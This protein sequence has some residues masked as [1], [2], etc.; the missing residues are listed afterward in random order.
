MHTLPRL[1]TWKAVQSGL[2]SRNDL[3][4]CLN[5]AHV[6]HTQQAGDFLDDTTY[7]A[8]TPG[9]RQVNF[10]RILPRELG[11]GPESTTDDAGNALIEL[12]IN[13]RDFAPLYGFE[14]A[15]SYMYEQQFGTLVVPLPGLW[16]YSAMFINSP[17]AG[18]RY[19]I[20]VD[21][22]P[23]KLEEHDF[24]VFVFPE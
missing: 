21:V 22:E 10:G 8:R 11:L 13:L 6:N 9:P 1:R 19:S 5:A 18:Y 16:R 4:V 3:L 2:H 7:S 23:T 24:I 14:L 20:R 15:L 12:G 17:R